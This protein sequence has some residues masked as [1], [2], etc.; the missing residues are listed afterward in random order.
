MGSESLLASQ[1]SRHG[2]LGVQQRL[3]VEGIMWEQL[4]QAF[5]SLS[6]P[7]HE[8]VLAYSQVYIAHKCVVY[9]WRERTNEQEHVPCSAWL[10][11]QSKNNFKYKVDR[12]RL[13][14]RHCIVSYKGLEHAWILISGRITGTSLRGYCGVSRLYSIDCEMQIKKK[15][16][17]NKVETNRI[18]SP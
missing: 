8:Y 6:W 14:T 12:C 15:H 4:R 18:S 5:A 17:R 7:L 2:E 1:S 10:L 9:T 3:C 16:Q 13:Y 11:E